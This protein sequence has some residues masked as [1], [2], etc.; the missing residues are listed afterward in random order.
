VVLLSYFTFG[1]P[2][3]SIAALSHNAKWETIFRA[4]PPT[5]EQVYHSLNDILFA[6]KQASS[7]QD[8]CSSRSYLGL[9]EL[10]DERTVMQK[11][12]LSWK[13]GRNKDYQVYSLESRS[14][15]SLHLGTETW[16]S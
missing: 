7:S 2:L 3:T 1:D 15:F 6:W 13:T 9:A 16:N 8:A 5:Q 10:K 12:D 14:Y 4:E 11:P